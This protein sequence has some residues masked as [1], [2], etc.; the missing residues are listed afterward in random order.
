MGAPGLT[1]AEMGF[2]FARRNC[3]ARPSKSYEVDILSATPLRSFLEAED[4]SF[5]LEEGTAQ[6]WWRRGAPGA[7]AGARAVLDP[8][9]AR[10]EDEQTFSEIEARLLWRRL[11]VYFNAAGGD[12][13]PTTDEGFDLRQWLI[14]QGPLPL[15]GR[16]V[17]LGAC[18]IGAVEVISI[19][20]RLAVVVKHL[21]PRVQ[22]YV[23]QSLAATHP[24]DEAV[25]RR[26][27]EV[28]SRILR[29]NR[30]P[31]E[32]LAVLGLFFLV[33]AAS[34]RQSKAM[35]ALK[36]A[37]PQILALRVDSFCRACVQSGK[38]ELSLR[39]APVVEAVAR[40]LQQPWGE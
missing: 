20:R 3:G 34:F 37:L 2:A 27:Y 31:E 15:A 18:L 23:R 7:A 6:S 35:G 24:L 39:I 5:S 8:V 26:V 11:P 1:S 28:Y 14:D 40:V 30:T 16:L 25:I 38:P 4:E 9:M 29:E 33:S 22:Q 13:T 19:R 36:S 10:V 32:E 12:L 17:I 21:P